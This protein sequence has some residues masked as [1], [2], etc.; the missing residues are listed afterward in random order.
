MTERHILWT[1]SIGI[2]I[3]SMAG[4]F[5]FTLGVGASAVKAGP[6]V[7]WTFL[8]LLCSLWATILSFGFRLGRQVRF[9]LAELKEGDHRQRSESE[10]MIRGFER[11]AL[12][13]II[14][15]SL[16]GVVGLGMSLHSIV[17][18]SIGILVGLH[19]FPLARIFHI[20]AYNVLAI[21]GSAISLMSLTDTFGSY[22]IEFLGIAMGS[23]MW[24]VA[25]YLSRSAVRL[26]AKAA[27]ECWETGQSGCADTSDRMIL[28]SSLNDEDQAIIEP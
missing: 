3:L 24:L 11:I 25:L 28:G 20:R 15:V 8:L 12:V 9:R 4:A 6:V 13:Q 17:W 23:M 22:R 21:L 7:L 19:F 16:I 10:R 26:A 2:I 1:L 18:P 14:L 27:S 5:W